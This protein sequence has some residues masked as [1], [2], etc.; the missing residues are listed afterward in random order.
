MYSFRQQL[1]DHYLNMPYMS[2][3]MYAYS[4]LSQ[5]DTIDCIAMTEDRNKIYSEPSFESVPQVAKEWVQEVSTHKYPGQN[6][7]NKTYND[8]IHRSQYS[9]SFRDRNSSK[10]YNSQPVGTRVVISLIEARGR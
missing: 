3:A 7:I 1:I 6:P 5:C 4:H 9:S 2:D 8:T 10:Q